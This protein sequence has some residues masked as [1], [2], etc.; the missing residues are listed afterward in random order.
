MLA[1]LRAIYKR[2]MNRCNV[3]FQL[4]VQIKNNFS[5]FY[6]VDHDARGLIMRPKLHIQTME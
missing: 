1:K 6:G 2:L 4:Q 5:A 3:S